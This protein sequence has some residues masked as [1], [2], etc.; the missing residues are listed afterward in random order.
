MLNNVRRSPPARM[1][2]RCRMSGFNIYYW[3][4]CNLYMQSHYN[5]F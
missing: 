1:L 4:S 3:K 2:N 5:R